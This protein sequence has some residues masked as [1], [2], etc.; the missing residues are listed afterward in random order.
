MYDVTANRVIKG[1]CYSPLATRWWAMSR[2]G[3]SG[4]LLRALESDV[5]PNSSHLPLYS[6]LRW[7]SYLTFGASQHMFTHL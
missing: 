1:G 6:H 5:D 7:T 2:A 4:A 3:G